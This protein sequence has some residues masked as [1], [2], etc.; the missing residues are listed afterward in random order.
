MLGRGSPSPKG[1]RKIL[2]EEE[3]LSWDLHDK[4]GQPRELQGKESPRQTA[5]L[6]EGW[7]E[8]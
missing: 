5:A 8:A 7:N 1:I 4:K 6:A 2:S 3:H